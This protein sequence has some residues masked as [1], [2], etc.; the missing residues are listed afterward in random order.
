MKVPS[1]LKY[2]KEHEWVKIEGN[3]AIIGITYYAQDSLGDIVFVELPSVGDA[4]EVEEPF[5]VVE[6]VKTAS[7]LY[8]PVS[9][10]VVEVNNEPMDSPEVVNQDPYG[11]GWMIMVEMSDPS[12]IEKLMSAEEYQALI[13]A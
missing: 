9:G 10:Q 3:R 4:V 2:T 8:A 11:Q 1:E 5:G 13:E 6:S 7:D 12:Q